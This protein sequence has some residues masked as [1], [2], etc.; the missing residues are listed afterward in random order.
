MLIAYWAKFHSPP[1]RAGAGFKP[2]LLTETRARQRH[3]HGEKHR[4]HLSS[5]PP[6]EI[7][8]TSLSA[9]EGKE[10]ASRADCRLP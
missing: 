10:K 1:D 2:V 8:A 3:S 6:A 7:P 5:Q 9:S 4:H